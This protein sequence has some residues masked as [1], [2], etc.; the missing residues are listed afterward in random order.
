MTDRRLSMIRKLVV[1]LALAAGSA[2]AF[3]EK[4]EKIPVAMGSWKGPSANTFKGAVRR[5][6]SKECAVVGG[7]AAKTARVVIDG[8][9]ESS[10]PKHF[11][12]RV[13]VKSPKSGEVVEQKEY[14]FSKA[15][16]TQ[17]QSDR[18]GREVSEIVRRAPAE[19]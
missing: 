2:S 7:K 1:V 14:K 13:I 6:L 19:T 5:G 4:T 18:M 9:V 10:D 12:V 11:V 3:A 8:E 17:A 15:S 16:A